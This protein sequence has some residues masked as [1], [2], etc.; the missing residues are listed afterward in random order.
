MQK[1]FTVLSLIAF[2]LI[3]LAVSAQAQTGDRTNVVWARSTEGAPITLDGVLD[4]AEWASAESIRVEYAA[5]VALI[6]GS[7]YMDEQGVLTND[8]TDATIK[9]LVVDNWLYLGITAKDSSVG[10]G[11]FN[12]FDGFLMNMRDRTS[13]N[14]PTPSFEY[15]YGWVTEGWADPA[16]GDI[17]ADPGFF[18]WAGG[19]RDS[20]NSQIWNAATT[21]IG[22]A[23]ADSILDEAWVTELAFNLD[24]RGYDATNE[25][26]DIVQFNISIYDSDWNWPNNPDKFAAN[27]T[28]LAGPWGN[29]DA[30][31]VLRIYVRPDVTVN[32][33][34]AP[35]IGPEAIVLNGEDFDDPT[36][37]GNL[38]EDVW[39]N[40][41]GLDIRYGDTDLRESYGILG[42]DRSG[43]FQPEIDGV[44]AAIL[45]PAD[46]TFKWFFKGDML[47][48]GVDVRDQAVWSLENYDMWDGIRIVINDREAV[49]DDH[50]LER[51]E[52]DVHFDETGAALPSGFLAALVDS[53]DG[54]SVGVHMKANTTIN[55]FNDVDEGFMIEL[56][57]DL[58]KLGYPSGRGDGILFISATLLDG[59]S[60]VNAGDNYGNRVWWMRES[61][62]PSAPAW[63]YMDPFKFVPGGAEAISLERPNVIWAKQTTET[64]T[65]D[66]MLNEPGWANAE[67]IRLQYGKTGSLIPGGGWVEERGTP[68]SDPTDAIVKFLVKDNGLYMAVE[69][70]DKS[71]GGGLFNQFD[72][73]LMNMRDRSS[74]NRPVPP[75]EYFYGW[76]TEGWADPATG[77]IGADPGFFGWAGGPRDSV[78]AQIW[79]AAT[80]VN[81]LANAD[82]IVDDSWVTEIWFNLDSRGYDATKSAGE[83]IEFNMSIY[84][85][86]WQWPMD[87]DKFSGNRTWWAGPWGNGSAYDVIRIYT[88][89]DVTDATASVPEVG[90]EVIIPSAANHDAPVIDGALSEEV[91]MQAPAMDIRF[92]DE[93][94]RNSYSGVGP[95]RSGQWQPE[96]DGVR[97]AVLDP[98]DATVKWFFKGTML[99]LGV[100]VRDQAVWSLENF[101]QWDAVNFII[102][103]RSVFHEIEHNLERHELIVRFDSTGALVTGGFLTEL[104]AMGGAEVAV[105]I[106]PNTTINDFNDVDEGF[107]FELALDLT[108]F[109]YAAD[110]GDGVLFLSATLFDG[111]SFEN[112]ADNYGTRTWWMRE[113]A[114]AAGPAWALMDP[115]T[116][117][118]SVK[119]TEN[120]GVPTEFAV[121]GNYPNPFN[122]TTNIVFTMPE[123]GHVALKIYDILG[124]NVANVPLGVQQTGKRQVSFDAHNLSSG[125]YFYRLHMKSQTTRKSFSTLYGKFTLLK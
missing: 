61:A 84:D 66:G 82:S 58:T 54:A 67:S 96:I 95:W 56:A 57:V 25:D 51:R 116:L 112:V 47:Y 29:G 111:D 107:S 74:P 60:F 55:D 103:N 117:V 76:V 28:W 23:N 63:A 65:L 31:D 15:F 101:D 44:R 1:T 83:I 115:N 36:I 12:Q 6:P 99:Y 104:M 17:G 125:V 46:A 73:F 37:D 119:T 41:P 86:D 22:L 69:A 121:L 32:S 50:V 88:R 14:R 30:Y 40:V 68:P 52:L 91:W 90:P 97:A 53:L 43:Q 114:W 9:F 80:K 21:V 85:A 4:E 105:E 5:N 13:E 20:I 70:K 24:A 38:S 16:T 39:G 7:G 2:L 35:F 10:G 87:P 26:G 92:D 123:E 48:I 64:I 77:D 81:G 78:T 124:R 11:L 120:T 8:P 34:G 89:P 122:P 109:G 71:I 75:F 100:D 93:D 18:G 79:N 49:Q 42:A 33:G 45:D 59:D 118:T 108:H 110:L 94:L 72:G 3:G 27:R 98:G 62:G 106:K 19:V 102:N 113:N